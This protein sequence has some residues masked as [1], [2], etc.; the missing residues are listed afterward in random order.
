MSISP[1]LQC[2]RFWGVGE[3]EVVNTWYRTWA[4]TLAGGSASPILAEGTLRSFIWVQK[5]WPPLRHPIF[6][7]GARSQFKEC[8][9]SPFLPVLVVPPSQFLDSLRP[10]STDQSAPFLRLGL[11]QSPFSSCSQPAF[12]CSQVSPCSHMEIKQN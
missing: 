5:P 3:G 11:P 8:S 6:P 7:K 1:F 9:L 4:R 2:F 10:L 12:I